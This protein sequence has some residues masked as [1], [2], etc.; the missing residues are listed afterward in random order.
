MRDHSDQEG[1]RGKL[2]ERAQRHCASSGIGNNGSVVECDGPSSAH[3][4]RLPSTFGSQH[5]R[6]Q[7]DQAGVGRATRACNLDGDCFAVSE[8]HR[9]TKKE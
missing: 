7:L 9:N 8:K 3:D 6:I 2:V 5:A 4:S 1:I